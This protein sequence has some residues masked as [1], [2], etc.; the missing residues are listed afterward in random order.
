MRCS[1][2]YTVYSIS[3][4]QQHT[5]LTPAH[6]LQ[7]II[8]CAISFHYIQS[9]KINLFHLFFVRA[10]WHVFH[11]RARQK[12]FP[13][14]YTLTDANVTLTDAFSFQ[15]CKSLFFLLFLKNR[16]PKNKFFICSWFTG[17]EQ[18][19]KVK[20]SHH[21]WILKKALLLNNLSFKLLCNVL[22]LDLWGL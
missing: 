16:N 5:S 20:H 7:N 19:T 10:A 17:S 18:Y 21:C 14:S 8:S 2:Q 22:I 3:K 4:S 6:T 12:Q 11:N 13:I 1:H 9:N 15:R